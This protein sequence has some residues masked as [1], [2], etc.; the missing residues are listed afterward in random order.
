MSETHNPQEQVRK[1]LIKLLTG[2]VL[3]FG[4]AFAM[5]PIY[6]VLCD[7]TGLNGR[8]ADTA[9]QGP[10]GDVATDRLITVEFVARNSKEM[11]WEFRCIRV[12]LNR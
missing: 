4:F 7:I 9:A 11:P 10:D 5:V 6:E 3:M 12:K 1:T 2:A 8:T